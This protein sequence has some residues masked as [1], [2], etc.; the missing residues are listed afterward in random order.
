LDTAVAATTR[1]AFQYRQNFSAAHRWPEALGNAFMFWFVGAA[2]GVEL[3]TACFRKKKKEKM[4]RFLWPL[5]KY[6]YISS[7][8][9]ELGN[10][11]TSSFTIYFA[12]G[13]TGP[14]DK[15]ARMCLERTIH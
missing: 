6:C 2:V 9:T 8:Q 15:M 5:L 13:Y 4:V 7:Q 12:N 10:D 11:A 1:E 14:M 3:Q